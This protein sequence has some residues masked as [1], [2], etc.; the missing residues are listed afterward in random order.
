MNEQELR[1]RVVKEIGREV[2]DSLWSYLKK[3]RYIRMT[4]RDVEGEFDEF[5]ATVRDRLTLLDA[6]SRSRTKRK[7]EEEGQELPVR[8]LSDSDAGRSTVVAEVLA[9]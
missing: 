4:L 8:E 6:D 1:S 2:P 7:T 5:V 3:K 9:K